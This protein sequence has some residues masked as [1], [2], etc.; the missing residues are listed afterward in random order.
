MAAEEPLPT[1]MKPEIYY[2]QDTWN[3]TQEWGVSRPEIYS[4]FGFTQHNG[5]DV[6][7]APN[8][9]VRAPFPCEVIKIGYQPNGGGIYISCI[10]N[11]AYEFPDG[12]KA[13]ILVDALHLKETRAI[14]GNKYDTGYVLAVGNNTGFSTGAHTHYQWRRVLK[15]PN[16]FEEVDTNK[17]NNSFD[18]TPY[19][20]GYSYE[21]LEKKLSTA[22]TQLGA[23]LKQLSIALLTK[24][25]V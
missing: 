4:R 14:V 19:F 3:I 23:L 5:I 2:P 11:E 25:R 13:W 21:N 8:K 18:P 20:V 7:L 12:K 16:G 17:A 9:L 1:T 10:S 22:Y 15:T 24:F 6:Q